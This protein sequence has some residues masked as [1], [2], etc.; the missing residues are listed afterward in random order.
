MNKKHFMTFAALTCVMGLAPVALADEEAEAVTEEA[1]ERCID[2]RRISRTVVVDAHTVLF[3]MRGGRIYRNTLP[4]KCMSLAR[5]KRFSYRTSTSRLCDVDVITVLY[6]M[7][8]LTRGPSCGLG[9]FYPVTKEEA[10]AIRQGPDGEIEP[11]PIE[12]AEMEQ[13]EVAA[14]DEETGE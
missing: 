5:E 1:S 7:G 8:G 4:H 13:P 3:Y 11:E 2:T 10:D 9:R 12:P 6:D 14:P